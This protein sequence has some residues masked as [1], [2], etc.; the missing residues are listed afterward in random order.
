MS[1]SSLLPLGALFGTS[2]AIECS[3]SAINA[4]LPSNATVNFAY[5]LPPN[6]TFQVP[7][8]D[9]GYPQ[10]PVGLPALCAVSVQVKS[11]GNSTFGFGLFLPEGWNGR[12]L[13]V[14]NGGFAGGINWADM[15]CNIDIP[16]KRRAKSNNRHQVYDTAS[17]QCRQTQAITPLQETDLG[18]T[19]VLKDLRIGD[20]WQCMALW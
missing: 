7:K 15:V 10:S 5:N 20:I 18:P 13:A 17:L 19:K 2:F 6:A 9:T 11:I 4:I 3:P 14:G 12:L 1:W 16:R 8:S